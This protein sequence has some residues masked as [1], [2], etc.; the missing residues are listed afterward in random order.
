VVAADGSGGSG[1]GGGLPRTGDDTSLPLARIGLAL[2]AAGGVV[3]AVA[4]KR[5]KA[6]AAV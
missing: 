5:R 3:T 4:A 6:T 1:T 2:A